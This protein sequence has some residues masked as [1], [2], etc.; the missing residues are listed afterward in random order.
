ML[1]ALTDD[2]AWTVE[3]FFVFAVFVQFETKIVVRCCSECE[4]ILKSGFDLDSAAVRGV[5]IIAGLGC[6]MQGQLVFTCC[7]DLADVS[8]ETTVYC[9]KTARKCFFKT[10]NAFEDEIE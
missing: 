5:S 9:E 8:N 3:D 2:F 7:D 10:G 1:I 6:C 4:V